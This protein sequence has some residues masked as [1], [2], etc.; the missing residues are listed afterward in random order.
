[1]ALYEHLDD[2]LEESSDLVSAKR[3]HGRQLLVLTK[4]LQDVLSC[5]H[6]SEKDADVVHGVDQL[7]EFLDEDAFRVA[8]LLLESLLVFT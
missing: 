8:G 3:V 7:A 6:A 5:V 2:S 1:M 4:A